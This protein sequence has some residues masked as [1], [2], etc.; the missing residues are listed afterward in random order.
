MPCLNVKDWPACWKIE[1]FCTHAPFHDLTSVK[2]EPIIRGSFGGMPEWLK[3]A[4]CKS[5]GLAP[6]LVR[7]QLPPPELTRRRVAACPGIGPG[8]AA[9]HSVSGMAGGVKPPGRTARRTES[10][11]GCSSMVE[12]KPSKL[13]T[14]V[15]FPSPAPGFSRLAFWQGNLQE[16]GFFTVMKYAHVAQW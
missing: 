16:G 3:G 15:R 8:G 7:I 14:R 5:V 6:T 2:K 9:A 12:Q 10:P 4:D 1:A 11:R 13:T